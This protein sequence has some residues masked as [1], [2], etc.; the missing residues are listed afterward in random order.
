MNISPSLV[1]QSAVA[2]TPGTGESHVGEGV[3]V[4]SVAEE[5]I[6]VEEEYSSEDV[7]VVISSDE[8]EVEES[9][10]VVAVACSSSRSSTSAV[11][12]VEVDV[13]I[14]S[15]V[16]DSVNA[17]AVDDTSDDEVVEVGS[18]VGPGETC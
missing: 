9:L 15:V 10:E 6:V 16:L 18:H 2:A 8:V 3:E 7:E 12:V 13:A 4:D 1:G 14:M 11:E 5:L 17:V